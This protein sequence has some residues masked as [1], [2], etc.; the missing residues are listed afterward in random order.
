MPSGGR[1]VGE[2]ARFFPPQLQHECSTLSL[3][4]G[5]PMS[6]TITDDIR[7]RLEE[8]HKVVSG[9][10]SSWRDALRRRLG[11]VNV[12]AILIAVI[13][14]AGIALLG[15]T[16]WRADRAIEHGVVA[17]TTVA[18]TGEQAEASGGAATGSQDPDGVS[19][20]S[21][22]TAADADEPVLVHV[23][24]AVAAPGVL[25]LPVGSRAADAVGAAGGA[26]PDADLARINLAAE[27]A[28]GQMLYVPAM[29]EAVPEAADASA[30][31]T[32]PGPVNLNTANVN[33]LDTLPG[34]GEST[35][36][37][38]VEHREQHGRFA[39]VEDLL[40]VKGIGEAK[41][42]DLADRVTV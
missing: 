42:A 39:S 6:D 5:E 7:A 28:D 12:D 41:L 2:V 32:Q 29:G 31:G 3:A 14:A 1:I 16:W 25:T 10:V 9:R 26:R 24:G 27:I 40:D 30:G 18:H 35:A 36:R 4:K 23:A 17:A 19:E 11:T 8:G 15:F 33:L 20:A 37:K 21:G 34:I 38:I 13:L 22:S